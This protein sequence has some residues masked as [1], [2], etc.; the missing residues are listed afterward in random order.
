MK[1]V[2]IAGPQVFLRDPAPY[3]EKV[4]AYCVSLGLI[5]LS[6]WVPDNLDAKGIYT[7]N[8][9]LMTRCDVAVA[10]VDPFRGC[11]PDSG[12]AFEIGYLAALGTPVFMY[13]HDDRPMAE[14]HR[15]AA[16]HDEMRVETFGFPHNLM[17]AASAT[18]V[19]GNIRAALEA[20]AK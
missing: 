4:E 11:E 5:M 20:A 19:K 13:G 6:P 7:R 14:K 2:Y 16:K 18:F 17:L 12:T 15:I 3:Y 1:R 10:S 9:Y 8:T